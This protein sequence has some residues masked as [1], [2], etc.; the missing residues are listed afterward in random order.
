MAVYPSN[1]C[2]CSF[3]GLGTSF[4]MSSYTL[5]ATRSQRHSLLVRKMFIIYDYII[6]IFNIYNIDK[7][8]KRGT[9][10]RKKNK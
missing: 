2:L 5:R 4:T 1:G 7:K 8:R 9:K 10:R 3:A 6:I